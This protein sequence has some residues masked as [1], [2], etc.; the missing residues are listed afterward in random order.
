MDR[1]VEVCSTGT[2]Y[3]SIQNIYIC[4]SHNVI[5]HTHTHNRLYSA[6]MDGQSKLIEVTRE[7][8][9]GASRDYLE[10]QPSSASQLLLDCCRATVTFSYLKYVHS[11]TISLFH[12]CSSRNSRQSMYHQLVELFFWGGD[13]S[14]SNGNKLCV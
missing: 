14:S 3:Y 12:Y 6:D 1:S 2:T 7:Y 10:N 8:L 13:N 4:Q 11:M 9:M 5:T